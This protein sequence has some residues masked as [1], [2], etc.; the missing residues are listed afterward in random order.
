[1][2][3]VLNSL[4][5]GGWHRISVLS[6]AGQGDTADMLRSLGSMAKAGKEPGAILLSSAE[7]A[8]R[9]GHLDTLT[10]LLTQPVTLGGPTHHYAQLMLRSVVCVGNT[11]AVAL[12]LQ[13]PVQGRHLSGHT[14]DVD[15][16]ACA[17]MPSGG[18]CLTLLLSLE[19]DRAVVPRRALE[20]TPRAREL[21]GDAVWH[22][23]VLRRGRRDMVLLRAAR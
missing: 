1:M 14:L 2:A 13:T 9:N 16:L 20:A 8:A 4:T 11:E 7:A 5:G 6:A 23:T 15:S 17:A 19:G 22:G 18:D 10:A 3:G 21:R 12:L